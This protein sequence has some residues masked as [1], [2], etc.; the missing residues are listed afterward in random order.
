MNSPRV[1]KELYIGIGISALAF[2]ILG[3]FLMRPYWIYALALVIGSVCAC[4]QAYSI[5]ETLDITLDLAPKKAKGFAM[6]RSIIRLLIC[7]GLM[8]GGI[9]IHWVAF[10]GVTI[11]LLT[12]K[13]S[14]FLNPLISKRMNKID[15]VDDT[16]D[17]EQK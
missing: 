5:Y 16:L 17:I 15:G 14:A 9:L 6:V 7:M 11:G 2:L 13:I 4:F 8:I 12:L 3:C 10:V 1:I